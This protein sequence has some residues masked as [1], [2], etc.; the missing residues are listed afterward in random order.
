MIFYP[1]GFVDGGF[2]FNVGFFGPSPH[3]LGPRSVGWTIL[4]P[5]IGK[6][7]NSESP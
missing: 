3:E 5:L 4:T 7:K 1:V 6:Y 2:F